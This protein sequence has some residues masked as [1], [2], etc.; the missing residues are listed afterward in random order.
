MAQPTVNTACLQYQ[1]IP[2]GGQISVPN[3]AQVLY[4]DENGILTSD[5]ESVQAQI[6]D[7]DTSTNCYGI[8][9]Q[10]EFD[11]GGGQGPWNVDEVR[12]SKIGLGSTEFPLDIPA[13]NT[14]ANQAL[15]IQTIQEKF[16]FIRAEFEDL[17]N[18]GERTT[19][20]VN[21][22]IPTIFGTQ[23]FLEFSTDT[24]PG[25][26]PSKFYAVLCNDCCEEITT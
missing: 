7:A 11:S 10:V 5:C 25:F 4:F 26:T 19:Y 12:V 16:P 24:V 23:F 14:P 21:L 6:D 2:A 1:T 22:I 17:G 9:W 20:R 18:V 13:L 15:L 8:N 3:G